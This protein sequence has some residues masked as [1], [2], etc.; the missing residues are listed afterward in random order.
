MKVSASWFAVIIFGSDFMALFLFSCFTPASLI[1][2]PPFYLFS[3]SPAHQFHFTCF[4]FLCHRA[5]D[6]CQGHRQETEK[7]EPL[8]H[9]SLSLCSYMFPWLPLLCCIIAPGTTFLFPCRPLQKNRRK[10]NAGPLEQTLHQCFVVLSYQ[11]CLSQ[12]SVTHGDGDLACTALRRT[13]MH[14][15]AS[16]F[17]RCL[18]QVQWRFMGECNVFPFQRRL[19]MRAKVWMCVCVC[20]HVR[21][22]SVPVNIVSVFSE[23]SLWCCRSSS[24]D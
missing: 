21:S 15:M 12:V 7:A 6:G 18:L 11:F 5:K 2:L 9:N 17:C 8:Y 16:F 1:S 3:S 20:V 14:T 13:L 10:L 4:L 19:G 22:K 23:I 24:Q